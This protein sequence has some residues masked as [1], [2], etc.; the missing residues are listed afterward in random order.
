M[1]GLDGMKTKLIRQPLDK[2]ILVFHLK[3]LRYPS[4]PGSSSSGTE[5]TSS[6]LSDVFTI[7]VIEK[8][9]NNKTEQKSTVRMRRY[10]GRLLRYLIYTALCCRKGGLLAFRLC[11]REPEKAWLR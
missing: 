4:A 11:K 8:W 6:C 3:N 7:D 5:D 1:A 2:D 9:M 10:V